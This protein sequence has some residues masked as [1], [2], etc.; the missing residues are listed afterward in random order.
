LLICAGMI[1]I[2]L[3]L[4]Q[5]CSMLTSWQISTID[6]SLQYCTPNVLMLM[7]L[8]I[9][10]GTDW[11]TLQ[12]KL[13]SVKE[14]MS[15]MWSQTVTTKSNFCRKTNRVISAGRVAVI[16]LPDRRR[17][18]NLVSNPI[19]DGSSWIRLYSKLSSQICKE[20]DLQRNCC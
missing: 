17:L 20:T 13:R 2:L 14:V 19:S 6:V 3:Q 11:R 1:S 4:I 7:S 8:P 15:N 5:H 9:S 12:D 10:G 16:L 18:R